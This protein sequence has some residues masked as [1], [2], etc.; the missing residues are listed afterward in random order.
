M[1]KVTPLKDYTESDKVKHVFH[2]NDN[3]QGVYE[4]PRCGTLPVIG[5]VVIHSIS[6]EHHDMDEFSD[7]QPILDE[8]PINP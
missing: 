8:T 7:I 2:T 5:G 1:S 3:R 6:M 4:C